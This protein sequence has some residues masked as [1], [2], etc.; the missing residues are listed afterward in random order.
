[1]AFTTVDK[2]TD[3]FNTKLYTGNNSSNAITGVGFQPDFVWIKNRTSANSHM[4]FDA[5]RGATYR[6]SADTNETNGQYSNSLTSFDSDGFT[7][8]NFGDVNANSDNFVSW[9]WK[10]QG[11]AGSANNDGSI[12]TTTTSVNTTAGISISKYTGTGSNATVGHGLGAVPKVVLV[13]GLGHTSQWYMYHI[14][15]GAGKLM[16]LDNNATSTTDTTSWQNTTPTS[17]VFSIG[18]DGGTNGS[19]NTYV[20]YCFAEKYGFSRFGSYK[21]TGAAN[22]GPFIYC[23]FSPAWVLVK[24]A[25]GSADSWFINDNKRAATPGHNPNSYYMRPNESSAEGTSA[26]LAIDI[27]GTGFKIKNTD[28]AYNNDNSTYIY[29]AFAAEPLVGSNNIAATAK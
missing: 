12:N 2:S 3:H 17:S 7:I 26:S 9:N 21:G 29:M 28:T 22:S 14:G 10:T 27:K 6:L 24:K 16:L 15:T 25:T 4:L 13:K 11:S 5:V 23:G 19:S 1:M 18:N 8:N 20:A